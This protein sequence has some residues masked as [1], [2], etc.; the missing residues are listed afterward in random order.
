MLKTVV[1]VVSVLCFWSLY[2]IYIPAWLKIL[3]HMGPEPTNQ[4]LALTHCVTVGLAI[5]PYQTADLRVHV[6]SIGVLRNICNAP[7]FLLYSAVYL[8]HTA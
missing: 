3:A 6:L 7:R 8:H 4:H 1:A 2:T 5:L